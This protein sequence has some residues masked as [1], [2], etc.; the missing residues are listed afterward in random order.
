MVVLEGMSQGLAV[1]VTDAGGPAEIVDHGV[2]GLVVAPRRPADLA[3]ALLDLC[4]DEEL[5]LRLGRAARRVVAERYSC[6]QVV[7][8]LEAVYDA[9]CRS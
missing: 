6:G 8:A 9:S 1:V 7:C 5:R 2:T 3:A 4:G